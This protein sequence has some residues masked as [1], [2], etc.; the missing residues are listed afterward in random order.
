VLE[1]GCGTGVFTERVAK[2]CNN[3]YALDISD[4][5]LRKAKEKYQLKDVKFLIA[6]A[7]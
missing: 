6:S 1:L 5:L 3:L 7:E 2:K 4:S